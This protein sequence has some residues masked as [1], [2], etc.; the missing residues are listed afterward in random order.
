[1]HSRGSFLLS[2]AYANSAGWAVTPANFEDTL[3]AMAARCLVHPT[4]LNDRD[5][6]NVP[7]TSKPG[8]QEWSRGAI[9]WLI[10]SVYN[11]SSSFVAH[12]KEQDFDISNQFFWMLPSEVA[13]ITDLPD[14]IRE[15]A[16]TALPPYFAQW[17]QQQNLSGD[18][19]C[20]LAFMSQLV[21]E[22]AA[23]RR[24]ANPSLHLDRWDA[25]WYQ[26]RHGF[27]RMNEQQNTTEKSLDLYQE[28]K[29]SHRRLGASLAKGVYEFG[30]LVD[31]VD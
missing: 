26:I 3:V 11:S 7:D 12:Y 15:M 1:M 16:A 24:N 31:N 17:H 2:S 22:T 21:Y 13:A 10:A 5:Q 30:F 19:E 25:G 28:L 27:L 4:W 23:L 18:A 29:R 8:Y 14:N 20:V 9:I 6:F